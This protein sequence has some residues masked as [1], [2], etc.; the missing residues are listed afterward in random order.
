MNRDSG[1]FDKMS[2]TE[3]TMII[4]RR[5]RFDVCKYEERKVKKIQKP[6]T[7]KQ[8]YALN[9]DTQLDFIKLCL[10]QMSDVMLFWYK[11]V[12]KTT[13]DGIVQ[14]GTEIFLKVHMQ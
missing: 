7:V 8:I 4:K 13:I 6:K 5:V 10:R 11:R 9:F 12:T 2:E 1:L 14:P 3:K